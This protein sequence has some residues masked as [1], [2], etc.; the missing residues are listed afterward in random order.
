MTP[1]EAQ[2]E[3][4]RLC[5]TLDAGSPSATVTRY[6]VNELRLAARQLGAIGERECN[7]IIGPDGFAKWDDED[8]DKADKARARHE[9]RIRNALAA[10]FDAETFN[11]LDIEF[12]GDPRGPAAYVHVKGGP[13]RVATFW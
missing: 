13:Q 7:G 3:Y 8:Q 5:N 9:K 4:Y 2:K 1:T 11:R 12:Q 10:L 6:N